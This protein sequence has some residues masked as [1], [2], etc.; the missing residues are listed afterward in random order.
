MRA[1]TSTFLIWAG[2]DGTLR[3]RLLHD[4][5]EVSPYAKRPRLGLNLVNCSPLSGRSDQDL[6]D[7]SVEPSFEHATAKRSSETGIPEDDQGIKIEES[8]LNTR[9]DEHLRVCKAQ[10]SRSTQS[11]A[12]TKKLSKKRRSVSARQADRK[13]GSGCAQRLFK[14]FKGGDLG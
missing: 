10:R 1:S 4:C 5:S 8:D 6:C 11:T 3:R 2:T 9:R 7:T 13:I 12:R 14:Q